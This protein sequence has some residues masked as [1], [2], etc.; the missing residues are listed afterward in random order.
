[1]AGTAGVVVVAAVAIA[2]LAHPTLPGPTATAT[3]DAPAAGSAIVP[4][5]TGA[6]A[7]PP[8]PGLTELKPTGKLSDV[9]IHDPSDPDAMVLASLPRT[10]LVETTPGGPLPQ[11]GIDGTR[12]VDAYARPSTVEPTKTRIA[13]V[14]GGLGIDTDGTEQAIRS[15]PGT[16][17]LAFAPYG[18]QLRQQTAEALGNGHELLLQVPL[19]PFNYPSTDPGPNTLTLNAGAGENRDRLHWFM[20]RMTNYVGVV[21]YMGARF[22]GDAK[23]L[24]PVIDEVGHRGLLYLDDGS[25]GM[26]KAGDLAPGVAPF[27]RA[28]IVL[29]ADLSADAIDQ[30]LNQLLTL[31]RQRGYAVATATAFPVSVERIAAFA[32][33]A[34]SR[35]FTI[36]PVTALVAGRS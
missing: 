24:K 27:L 18:E 3:I 7:P 36:V 17:T 34:A 26:S 30:H 19:E 15:L 8:A 35:G 31:A 22:T 4:E 28:D 20:S 12:P 23:V 33:S 13:I 29:D 2:W 32:A 11:I 1:M 21:N 6:I 10:D 16:V 25:S 5:R 9:V 14:V